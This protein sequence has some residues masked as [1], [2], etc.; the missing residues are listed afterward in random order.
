M[1][2]ISDYAVGV[3]TGVTLI[4]S[5]Y[6]DDGPMWSGHGPRHVIQH[7]TFDTPFVEEPAVHLSLSMWDVDNAAVNRV[8]LRVDDIGLSGFSLKFSTWG[9]TRVARARASWMAIGSVPHPDNF[10]D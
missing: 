5:D 6:E 9:D 8:D 7:V 3:Q 4:F 1:I 2:R 10:V